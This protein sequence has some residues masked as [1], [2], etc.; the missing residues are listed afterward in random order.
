[1]K[2]KQK[3][4]VQPAPKKGSNAVNIATA[5][6]LVAMVALAAIAIAIPSKVGVPL[7]DKAE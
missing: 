5:I 6:T 1:M 7:E 3:V 4:I 2:K